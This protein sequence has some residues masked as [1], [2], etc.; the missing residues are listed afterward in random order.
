MGCL[1]VDRMGYVVLDSV[2]HDRFFYSESAHESVQLDQSPRSPPKATSLGSEACESSDKK[3][4][5]DS[6]SSVVKE[7]V[8]EEPLSSSQNG[9]LTVS[10][11]SVPKDQE[12]PPKMSYASI[13]SS[14]RIW[15]LNFFFFCFYHGLQRDLLEKN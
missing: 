1:P 2:L 5:P 6:N 14:L 10:V 8:S 9:G 13:V 15:M 12:D 3:D 4:S 11:K 7:V